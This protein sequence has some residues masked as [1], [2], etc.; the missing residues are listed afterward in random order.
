[1]HGWCRA[2]G[3]GGTTPWASLPGSRVLEYFGEVTF[4]EDT[5]LSA[6][7][8]FEESREG[9]GGFPGGV[10]NAI[11][12]FLPG[13]GGVAFTVVVAGVLLIGGLLFRRI[14]R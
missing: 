14:F 8:S 7:V 10:A 13:T 9:A 6:S 1:M 3:R 12:N 4:E 2:R 11:G 5:T